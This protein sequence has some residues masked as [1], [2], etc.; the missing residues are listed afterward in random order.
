MTFDP[1]IG[2]QQEIQARAIVSRMY[3]QA[4]AK[5]DDPAI[6]DASASTP[7]AQRIVRHQNAIERLIA[8]MPGWHQ[9][10]EPPVV[11]EPR[12]PVH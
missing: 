3:A 11:D 8:E 7:Y 10:P 4:L 6:D 9:L 12:A 2:W 1:I 5:G